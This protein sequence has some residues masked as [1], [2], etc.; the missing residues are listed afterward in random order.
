LTGI[1][2]K[3]VS[4]QDNATDEYTILARLAPR[5]VESSRNQMSGPEFSII[6]RALLWAGDVERALSYSD[7]ALKR[8]ET[9]YDKTWALRQYAYTRIQSGNTQEG[10]RLYSQALAIFAAVGANET[11][12]VATDKG[13]TLEDWTEALA[14]AG[15]CERARSKEAEFQRFITSPEPIFPSDRKTLLSKIKMVD[16]ICPRA[17]PPVLPKLSP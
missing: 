13:Y 7:T 10:E 2:E 12:P 4:L 9:T 17:A 14:D 16:E 8:A 1:E 15:N 5:L 6:A 11:P 3:L